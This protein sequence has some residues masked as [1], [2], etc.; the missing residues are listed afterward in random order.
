VEVEEVRRQDVIEWIYDI[1]SIS[2]DKRVTLS[3]EVGGRVA[4]VRA[5]MG[6]KVAEG[7]LLARLD[8]ERNRIA[9]D[10]AIADVETAEANLE[11]SKREAA[12]ET[13]LFEDQITSQHSIDKAELKSRID[14]GQLKV[15]RAALAAAER[16]LSDANIAS[17]ID[18]EITRRH[19]ETGEL[20]QPGTPLFDIANIERVKVTIQVSERDITAIRKGQTA[21]IRVDGYPGKVFNGSVSSIGAEADEQTRTF[22]VEILVANDRPERLL[23]GF[24]GRVQ[25]RGRIFKNVIFLSQ[26]VIVQRKGRPVVFVV[27]SDTASARTV[28]LGYANRGKVIITEGLHP[29]DKVVITGQQSLRDGAKISAR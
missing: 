26:E 16:N 3:A 17:P 7:D 4:E 19:I 21:E 10:K 22:P 5:D 25:I 20:V 18:G 29:G 27:G 14:A 13:S 12:R 28:E 15:A 11:N 24:I 9:R 6:D 8:D 2:A 1:G 23:P